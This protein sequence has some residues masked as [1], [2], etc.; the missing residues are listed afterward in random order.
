MKKSELRQII[1]EEISMVL[2]ES[3]EDTFKIKEERGHYLVKDLSNKENYD[4]IVDPTEWVSFGP[5]NVKGNFNVGAMKRYIEENPSDGSFTYH[6]ATIVKTK[7]GK[8]YYT[9]RY[10]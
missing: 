10:K 6:I 4:P 1:K 8:E 9:T 3:I 5:G 2:K 7:Q